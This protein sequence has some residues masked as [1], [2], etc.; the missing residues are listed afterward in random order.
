[1]L[2][3]RSLCPGSR[4]R[5]G[6]HTGAAHPL[7]AA[8]GRAGALQAG[9][10]PPSPPAAARADLRHRDDAAPVPRHDRHLVH[11]L[12]GPAPR[13]ARLHRLRQLRRRVH[14][15][16]DPLGGRHHDPADRH[17]RR[18][19]PGAR[20]AHRPAARPQVL[21]PRRG[22]H[23][24][25]RAVPHRARGRRPAVEARAVQPLVRAVQRHAERDLAVLRR[26]ARP[27][28]RLAHPVP[29]AVDRAVADLAVDPVH[30]AD[31]AGRPAVQ[32]PRRRRGGADG[33]RRRV[34]D[35]P[36]HH[37]PAPAPLPRA[38]RAAGRHLHRPELRRGVHH[39]RR[40]ARHGEPALH[41][42]RHLLPAPG[43]RPRLRPGRRRR[44]RHDHHRHV[45]AAD[46]LEP[47]RRR[48]E[49]PM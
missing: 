7:P 3:H 17:R 29:A 26:R 16:L 13:P 27:A 18:R 45:R 49:R 39:H 36:L 6:P 32:A 44:H 24:D 38:R 20:H 33:R 1:E 35:L 48:G 40:R 14:Q 30:D 23:D 41:D 12:P 43:L 28:G 11:G 8:A 22:A 4:T 37:L 25:D 21:R 47:V 9:G 42:L 46:G 15:P 10:P 31:P 2:H 19:Q 5:A 34:A